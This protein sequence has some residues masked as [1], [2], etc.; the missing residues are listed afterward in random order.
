MYYL[1]VLFIMWIDILKVKLKPGKRE[2]VGINPTWSTAFEILVLDKKGIC[3][4]SN[5]RPIW[6]NLARFYRLTI[7]YQEGFVNNIN[8]NNKENKFLSFR[9]LK[10]KNNLVYLFLAIYK[11]CFYF[12][13]WTRIVQTV[14]LVLDDIIESFQQKENKMVI[15]AVCK[16]KPWCWKSL[17]KETLIIWCYLMNIKCLS[18]D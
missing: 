5:W 2:V 18:Y 10:S 9:W 17:K 4:I 13:D 12:L 1:C 15:S 8:K 3:C 11:M 16:Q 6:C 14:K 7:C